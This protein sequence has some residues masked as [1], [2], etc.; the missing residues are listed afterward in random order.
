MIKNS[1]EA[2]LRRAE[3]A[4]ANESRLARIA[5][6]PD[7]H[8][9]Q[10]VGHEYYKPSP[11]GKGHCIKMVVVGCK[12]GLKFVSPLSIRRRIRKTGGQLL[13]GLCSKCFREEQAEIK[14]SAR[15][16]DLQ[17]DKMRQAATKLTERA[18]MK[19]V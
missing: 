19:N 2:R 9:N 8:I 3:Q 4:R 6:N 13:M 1:A 17:R 18:R 15:R 5:A 10:P 11:S 14:A 7:L 12:C 16:A